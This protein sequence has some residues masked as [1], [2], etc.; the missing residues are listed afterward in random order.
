[1]WIIGPVLIFTFI[2]NE[3]FLSRVYIEK[4]FL[5]NQGILN[6]SNPPIL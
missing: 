3:D 2:A 5:I 4:L 6:G 1:M